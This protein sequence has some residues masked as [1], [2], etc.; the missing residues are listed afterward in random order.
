MS[1]SWLRM[2]MHQYLEMGRGLAWL[3]SRVCTPE[4]ARALIRARLAKRDSLFL[5]M[6]REA[7]WQNPRSPYHHLLTAAGWTDETLAD[8]VQ[9]R[10]IEAT[11][12]SL[13]DSGVFLTHAEFKERKPIERNGLHLEWD[14]LS[15]HHP[16]VLPAFEVRTGGTRSRG[17]RVPATFAYLASQRA[18]TWCLTLEAV[19][20]GRW[21]AVIWM[22]REASF[23]WWLVLASM[24]RPAVRWFSMVDFS[25]VRIP[26]LHLL[27]YRLGQVAGLLRGLRLPYIE[28]VP[29]SSA[30]AVYDAVSATRA[31]H[32]GCSVITTPSGATRL[33]GLA[34]RFGHDLKSVAFVV[35]AE[36][37]TPGKYAEIAGT[38]ARV[39]VRY[40]ITEIG[41]IGGACGQPTA[42]DDVHLLADSFGFIPDR[43]VLPD[44]EAVDGLMLT[45]L[46]PSSPMALLN[47][48]SDDFA[49]VTTR[50]C[51]CLWDD[52]GLHTHFSRIRSFS[53]LTGEGVTVLGTECVRIIEEV[54]PREFGGR[55]IDYQ[56]LEVEDEQHLTRLHLLVSPA[57]GPVDEEKV[58][59]RFQQE[60]K[61]PVPRG[62]ALPP[63]WRQ[64]DTIKVVRREPV[65][66]TAG[67]LLPF[68]TL[69]LAQREDDRESGEAA[70]GGSGGPNE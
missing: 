50:R 37:L 56:L 44:G 52:L 1:G 32:G 41:A 54:L 25:Y 60:V 30:E 17:D 68:H 23:L 38:G 64:A 5:Q 6:V 62:D 39:G 48:D 70:S 15:V 10:G 24:R 67:K 11:L 66:T 7:I 27:M 36:P 65:S 47:L 12:R 46:L 20:G 14:D 9:K 69:A 26:Q 3:M 49:Q 61:N 4:S 35:G 31:R 29:L 34:G 42:A 43:R 63:M 21:P 40:N 8:A 51:G 45:T 53:K 33:A 2:G 55:S 19:G 28:Y 18:P 57:V 58:L 16:R 59:A 22:P 13:R